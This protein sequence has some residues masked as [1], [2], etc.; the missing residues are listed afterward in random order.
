M[1][2]Q[3]H[4]VTRTSP[5]ACFQTCSV[6]S[7]LLVIQ[8]YIKKQKQNGAGSECNANHVSS[9][10]DRV[11]QLSIF[12][13]KAPWLN[14]TIKLSSTLIALTSVHISQLLHLRFIIK[15]TSA[16]KGDTQESLKVAPAARDEGSNENESL[17][18]W[19]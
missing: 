13:P 8:S 2:C 18:E 5:L 3:F 6:V 12:S 7:V 10:S 15:I 11:T 14:Q 17:H 19:K 1:T 16:I 4:K 9:W